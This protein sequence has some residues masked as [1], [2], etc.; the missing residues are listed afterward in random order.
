MHVVVPFCVR[1][2]VCVCAV[3][4]RAHFKHLAFLLL[5][6]GSSEALELSG[7]SSH[8]CSAAAMG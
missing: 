5:H 6:R 4:C 8:T 1:V 7:I 3:L 2:C